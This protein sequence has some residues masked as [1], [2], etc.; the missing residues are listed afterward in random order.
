MAIMSSTPGVAD[1]L[2]ATQSALQAHILD[3][4][5]AIASLVEGDERAPIEF[6]LGVYSEAYHLRLIEAL[7]ANFPV[8]HRVLGDES[9]ARLAQ[10]YLAVNP[11]R[12]YSIRWFG[13]RLAEYLSQ[14]DEYCAQRWLSEL[15]GWEWAVAH[16]FDA[17]D[18]P[19]LELSQ[20][21]ALDASQWPNL[22]LR[23]HP[24]VQVVSVTTNV[25]EL[26]SAY[27]QNTELPTLQPLDAKSSA[28][29]Q[30]LIWRQD[31]IVKYRP[32]SAIEA[33]SMTTVQRGVTFGQLCEWLVEHIEADAV[34]MHAASLLKTWMSEQ[35]LAR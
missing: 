4:D 19:L 13:H 17:A 3:G 22:P 25:A 28:A 27:A 11:S 10:Q 16:A 20:V 9:F 26:A 15:A 31:L 5:D 18:S 7:Q 6:R 12:H 21:A 14:A 30:W 2:Q 29:T 32:L 35:M 1:N 8:L 23:A 34:P 33:A 24:S